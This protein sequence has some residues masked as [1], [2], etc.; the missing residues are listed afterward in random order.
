[1]DLI[2]QSSISKKNYKKFWKTN[3]RI[4]ERDIIFCFVGRWNSQKDF[5]TL[6]LR[7]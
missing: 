7:F 3:L 1:M 5:Q 4:K 2:L 6:F